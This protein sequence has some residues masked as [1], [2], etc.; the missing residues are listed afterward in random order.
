MPTIKITKEVIDKF[1]QIQNEEGLN[2]V[3]A[4]K[5][6]GFNLN[7]IRIAAARLNIAWPKRVLLEDR[8]KE[9]VDEIR[10]NLQTQSYW[11]QEFGVSQPRLQVVFKKLGLPTKYSQG[12]RQHL[13]HRRDERVDHAEDGAH[14]EQGQ[15]LLLG[16]APHADPAEQPGGRTE[17]EGVDDDPDQ[18]GHAVILLRYG[19]ARTD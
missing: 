15:R 10:N 16:V 5:R 11:A 14:G 13:D 2:Q 9:R 19:V 18:E 1:F 12:Q 8:V 7:A 3:Q 4:A 17:G 6:L